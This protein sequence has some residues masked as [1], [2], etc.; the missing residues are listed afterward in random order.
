MTPNGQNTVGLKN[1]FASSPIHEDDDG[2]VGD[3]L[4]RANYHT[5]GDSYKDFKAFRSAAVTGGFGFGPTTVVNMNYSGSPT[6]SDTGVAET[7]HTRAADIAT[8]SHN[9]EGHPNLRVNGFDTVD[10]NNTDD[11]QV[12]QKADLPGS[13]VDATRSD[14]LGAYFTG[15]GNRS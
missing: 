4:D 10:Y 9:I 7:I 5:T 6:F 15:A 3:T 8:D 12:T 14:T 2:R 11:H 1:M 13:N